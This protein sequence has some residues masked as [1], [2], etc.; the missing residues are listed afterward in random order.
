MNTSIEGRK[1]SGDPV[2]WSSGFI[3]ISPLFPHIA[4]SIKDKKK[5]QYRIGLI[6]PTE[7]KNKPSLLSI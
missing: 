2:T 5:M 1:K 7:K 4:W 3:L 6:I